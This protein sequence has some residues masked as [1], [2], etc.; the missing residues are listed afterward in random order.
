MLA[1]TGGVN[2][3]R[4]AIWALGLLA[5]ASAT[6]TQ[7]EFD[8]EEI[9]MLAGRIARLPTSAT[10]DASH[11]RSMF[12]RHGA[13]GA[14]GEAED[15]FAHVRKIALP[16]LHAARARLGDESLARLHVLIALLSRVD[17]TCVLYRGGRMALTAAKDGAARV[18]A[19]GVGT[20]RGRE[21]LD[22]LDRRLLALNA[23][24]GGCADL[25]AATLF[26]DRITATKEDRDGNA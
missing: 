1:A 19:A 3:H 25:L 6:M 16:E 22:A 7:D 8:A 26:V 14:R 5:A 23:S 4:G 17:D 15:G 9:C 12:I 21:E 18:L 13:R 24:P 2:T 10:T 11:G 20:Q